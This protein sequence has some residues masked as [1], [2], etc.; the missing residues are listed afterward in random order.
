MNKNII[1]LLI[2]VGLSGCSHTFETSKFDTSSWQAQGKS[3][4]GVVYYEPQ[5]VK[6]QYSF[7]TLVDKKG[8]LLGTAEGDS[9]KKVV[10]KE[11]IKVLPN[12][13]EPRVIINKPSNWA[14]GKFS[15]GLKDG[16]LASINSESNPEFSEIVKEISGGEGI[17]SLAEAPSAEKACNSSPVI[18]DCSV[19]RM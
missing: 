11:E 5:L 8:N 1:G 15:V 18:S 4:E 13:N 16:M 3:V 19:V 12:Y 9:C 10:Q 7:T 6:I 2:V 14:T 17:L